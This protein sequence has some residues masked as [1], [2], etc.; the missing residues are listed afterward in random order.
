LT[1]VPFRG[2]AMP[3]IKVSPPSAASSRTADDVT[4]KKDVNNEKLMVRKK[5]FFE[6]FL[7][8]KQKILFILVF[9]S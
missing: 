7:S 3:N 4:G 8:F 5:N 6:D 1:A 9:S 2:A